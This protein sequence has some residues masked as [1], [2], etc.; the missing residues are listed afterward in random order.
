MHKLFNFET[1][2]L[3]CC[4]HH[5]SR[6]LVVIAGNCD[7]CVL[8]CAFGLVL[9]ELTTVFKDHSKHFLCEI[10]NL[11]IFL[12][13]KGETLVRKVAAFVLGEIIQHKFGLQFFEIF[14]VVFQSK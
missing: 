13:I 4:S 1:G 7:H 5:K 8:H 6:L 10:F 2:K 14:I 3:C 9:S 12:R 11:I